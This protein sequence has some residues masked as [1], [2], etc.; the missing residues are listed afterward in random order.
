MLTWFA[1]NGERLGTLGEPRAY[2][3]P[4]ISRDGRR[5]AVEVFD[6]ATGASGTLDIFAHNHFAPSADGQR[7]LV[8]SLVTD[9]APAPITVVTN[10]LAEVKR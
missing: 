6:A 1:R 10:W 3:N 8:N 5:I 2:K 9:A 4:A 7:F